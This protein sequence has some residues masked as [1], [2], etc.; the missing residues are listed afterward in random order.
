M[1]EG[2]LKHCVL[3]DLVQS[4]DPRDHDPPDG[5]EAMIRMRWL[6]T[7]QRLRLD[8]KHHPNKALPEQLRA[9]VAIIL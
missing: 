8:T 9:S 3:K 6:H 4:A 7:K 5:E 2:Q 1:R